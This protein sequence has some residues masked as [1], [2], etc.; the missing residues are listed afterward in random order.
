MKGCTLDL[1][2]HLNSDNEFI[3]CDLFTLT[4][5]NGSVYRLADFDLDISYNGKN[6]ESGRFVI[7][8]EQTKIA[9]TPSVETLSVVINA[10][11]LHSADTV[12]NMYFLEA[13]HEGTLD[14]A[15]LTLGRAFMDAETGAVLGVLSL[16]HGRCEVSSCGGIMCKISAKS[17]TVGL[18]AQVPIRTFAPQNV[19]QEQN[20]NVS[21][22]SQDV[23][24]CMIPLK[25]S[26]NVLV[27]LW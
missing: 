14:D 5:N 19:Y 9:G 23:Y 18:N 4:L 8:R 3:C 1:A 22:A 16:F 6:Y 17:E 25:P 20:G 26:K 10:D 15:Y 11:R 27:K 7:T 24:T 13:V 21:T 2:E 12:D